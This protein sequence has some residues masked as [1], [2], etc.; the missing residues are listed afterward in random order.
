MLIIRTFIDKPGEVHEEAYNHN[1]EHAEEIKKMGNEIDGIFKQFG[2]LS[3][4][5]KLHKQY[6]ILTIKARF[7][8]VL[9]QHNLNV[10]T[11]EELR[12]IIKAGKCT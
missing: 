3:K 10:A 6:E 2:T 7:D 5:S 9:S 11:I 1:N 8:R 4:E 12:S